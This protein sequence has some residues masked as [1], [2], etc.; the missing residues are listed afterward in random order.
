[1]PILLIL[2]GHGSHETLPF[3]EEAVR[4]NIH[5]LMLPAHTTHKT[6][7]LDVGCFG[8]LKSKWIERC[9]EHLELYG[10]PI[11]RADFVTEYL[12]VR[13][14]AVTP[15]LVL[16]A[17]RKTGI[18]PFNPDIFNDTDFAPSYNMLNQGA[19]QAHTNSEGD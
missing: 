12:A 7:P 8:P 2:D 5:I 9:E 13:D 16:A 3:L 15:E 4:N 18:A 1:V 14:A 10:T 19:G 11:A 6:Q 17:F